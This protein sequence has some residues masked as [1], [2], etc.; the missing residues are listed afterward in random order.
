[1]ESSTDLELQALLEEKRKVCDKIN[2]HLMS[3]YK[4]YE[5]MSEEVINDNPYRYLFDST[6]LIVNSSRL[7][8]LKRM[9][10]VKNYEVPFTL[11]KI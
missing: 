1:M 11:L 9:G 7:M 2:A 6:L 8:A 10:V 3:K 5:K 4:K